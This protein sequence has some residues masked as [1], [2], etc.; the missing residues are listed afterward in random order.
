VRPGDPGVLAIATLVLGAVA[1][2]ACVVPARLATRIDP[3]LALNRE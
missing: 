1:L 2:T 3:V